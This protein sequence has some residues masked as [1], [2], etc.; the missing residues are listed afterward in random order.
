MTPFG[1]DGVRKR[2]CPQTSYKSP[3]RISEIFD[4]HNLSISEKDTIWMFQ[5]PGCPAMESPLVW[6]QQICSNHLCRMWANS[7]CNKDHTKFEKI[8]REPICHKY[9]VQI[10]QSGGKGLVVMGNGNTNSILP[11]TLRKITPILY[12]TTILQA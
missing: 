5:F 12:Y 10:V 1:S 2:S 4:K 6:R 9:C 11:L 8:N 7:G 3:L